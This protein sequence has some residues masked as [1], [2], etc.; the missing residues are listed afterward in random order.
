MSFFQKLNNLIRELLGLRAH[1]YVFIRLVDNDM[2]V[3]RV[4]W[5]YGKAFAHPYL[6]HTMREM[7]PGGEFK[8]GG[9]CYEWYPL[10]DGAK[11]FYDYSGKDEKLNKGEVLQ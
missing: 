5:S 6:K 10:T 9:Y 8:N 7:V 3:S 2:K 1:D 4:T 11:A